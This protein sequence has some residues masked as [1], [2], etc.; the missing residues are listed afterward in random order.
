MVLSGVAENINS[1]GNSV[2]ISTESED[3]YEEARVSLTR[4]AGVLGV[5]ERQI[6]NLV[7]TA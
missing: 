3:I 4:R 1:L 5:V 2:E 6:S 7:L